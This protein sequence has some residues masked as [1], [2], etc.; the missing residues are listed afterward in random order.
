MMLGSCS[1][2]ASKDPVDFVTTGSSGLRYDAS[3]GHFV[4]S[5]KTPKVSQDTCYRATVTLADG[6][7]IH[8]LFKLRK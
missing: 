6:T 4:Q 2:G 7:A 8:A 3:A 1:A 5:W